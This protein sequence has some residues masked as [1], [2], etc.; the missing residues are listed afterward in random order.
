MGYSQHNV[1]I[2]SI[3]SYRYKLS[4]LFLVTKVI[5]NKNIRKSI[6]MY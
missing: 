4:I 3:I 5:E 2:K 1:I 6:Y